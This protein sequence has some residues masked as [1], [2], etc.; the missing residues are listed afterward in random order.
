MI[1]S[2]RRFQHSWTHR[3]RLLLIG[4]G[5]LVACQTTQATEYFVDRKGSDAAD[6]LTPGSAFASIQKG[7]DALSPGDTLT[8]EPGEYFGSVSRPKLGSMDADTIIRAKIPGTVLLRGDVHAPVF[9]RVPGSRQ[10]YVTDFDGDVHG[11][12]EDD[13]LK[14]L[15][16]VPGLTELDF[17]AGSFHYDKEAKKLT[18]SPTDLRP[19]SNHS[20]SVSIVP[21]HGLH[22]E[23][24]IRVIVDGLAFRGFNSLGPT[25]DFRSQN[26]NWGIF[27]PNAVKC[28]IRNSTAFLNG[29]GIAITTGEGEGN[30]VEDCVGYG[31]GAPHSS[32]SGNV[33]IFNGNN[34]T[35]RNC[36]GYRS[37]GTGVRLYGVSRGANVIEGSLGWGNRGPDGNKGPG[38]D[39]PGVIRNTVSLHNMA[40]FKLQHNLIG[41]RLVNLAAKD[42]TGDNILLT[43][44]DL[45][46]QQEFVDPVNFDFRLQSNSKLRGSAPDGSD[47]GPFPFKANVYFVRPGGD[48][49]A[50]GLSTKTAWKTAPRAFESLKSGDTVYFEESDYEGP[51][52]ITAAKPEGEPINIRARGV[53]RVRFMDAVTIDSSAG[54]VFERLNFAAPF[55]VKQSSDVSFISCR[56]DANSEGLAATDTSGLRVSHC[57]FTGNPKVALS[58]EGCTATMLSSNLFA[59]AGGV[60]VQ[61]GPANRSLWEGVIRSLQSLVGKEGPPLTLEPTIL[62]SN[63]N[64]YSNPERVWSVDGQVLSLTQLQEHGDHQSF[65]AAFAF[66]GET[67]QRVLPERLLFKAQGALG[68]N[69]GFHQDLEGEELYMSAPVVHSVTSTTAN[70][71]WL[72]S[73]G[74]E[75]DIAWGETPECENKQ[76]FTINT[77]MDLFRTYS[78]TGLKPG[79]KYYFRVEN[80]RMLPYPDLGEVDVIDPKTE[81]ITFTTPASDPAPRALYVAPD[82]NDAHSGLSREHAWRSVAHAASQ[83]APG[84][85]VWIAGGT[86]VEKVRVRTTGDVGK[87]I[88]FRSLPGEKVV[89]D[90]N[91]RRLD[92]AWTINGKSNIV[93]DGFYFLGHG[94]FAGGNV[95]TRLFDIV[96]SRDILINRCMM[97]GLGGGALCASFLTAWT[98][99]NL[100]VSNCASILAPDS[101]VATNCPNLKIENSVFLLTMI[102]NLRLDTDATLTSNIFCD[103]GQYKALAKVQLQIYRGGGAVQDRNNCYYFRLPDGER[104]AFIVKWP[105]KISLAGL[106]SLQPETDS[107]IADPQF[108]I[109]N[110]VPEKDRKE[111]T[112][113]ALY[114]LGN[115]MDFSGLFATNPEVIARGSGL[116]PDAFRDFHFADPPSGP[117]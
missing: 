96:Q 110:K 94:G 68:K 16:D 88:S 66:T 76:K 62:I 30:L 55:N 14:Q 83:A 108:A 61:I 65:S 79:T 4:C 114:K 82:G 103:S 113:D 74:A 77:L 92:N 93:V 35:I 15:K 97:N 56:F 34:D 32:E 37:I 9:H 107:Y 106:K 60:A 90:G 47:R 6:G 8:I 7:V 12:T 2:L 43:N 22:I 27:L 112:V 44:E 73:R 115:D 72:V 78:L 51:V 31:N 41:H 49:A 89:F 87:P 29:G 69:V 42:L 63:H 36:T 23:T 20:Y 19:A 28:V 21:N 18:I 53:A 40:G 109:L 111:F 17:S 1:H 38:K 84:D 70:I 71:E 59:N 54:L 86:Y 13:T 116:Q 39:D 102:C 24:P 5:M 10:S 91:K 101:I 25:K 81:V 100:T 3:F 45:S 26:V 75:C 85:T 105:D 67:G 64:A 98:T 46:L 48:D 58:L 33:C 95:A 57:E 52:T 80:I 104:T 117:Q 11:V 50:D 99:P